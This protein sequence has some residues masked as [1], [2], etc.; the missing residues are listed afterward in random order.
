MDKA[1]P[2]DD[3]GEDR[4]DLHEHHDVVGAGGLPDTEDKNNSEDEDDQERG[5]IEAG[6][7]SAREDVFPGEVLQAKRKIGGRQPLGRK[8][9]AEPVERIH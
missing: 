5:D 7:P 3:E 4:G 8:M 1:G 9:D 2:K 6:V